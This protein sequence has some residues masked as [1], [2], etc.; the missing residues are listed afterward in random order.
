MP[1]RGLDHESGV[2]VVRQRIAFRECALQHGRD[3]PRFGERIALPRL[4]RGA[5]MDSRKLA[6]EREVLGCNGRM[7]TQIVTKRKVIALLL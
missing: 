1:E 7:G 2:I 5:V 6:L 3:E 4:E